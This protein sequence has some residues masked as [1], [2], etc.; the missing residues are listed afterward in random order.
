MVVELDLEIAAGRLA[1]VGLAVAVG[2]TAKAFHLLAVA[3]STDWTDGQHE[4][5][6]PAAAAAATVAAATVAAE[7][8]AADKPVHFF[9]ADSLQIESW[10][11]LDFEYFVA[12]AEAVAAA[13]LKFDQYF[14]AA[15]ASAAADYEPDT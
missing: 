14:A 12:A 2:C 9:A 7:A 6:L 5:F 15:V 4:K 13:L 11:H 1:V 3:V 8:V 10:Q